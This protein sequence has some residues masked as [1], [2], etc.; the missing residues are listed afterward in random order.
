MTCC[1]RYSFLTV[2]E[3]GMFKV[4][5]LIRFGSW[6]RPSW[7]CRWLLS[8][9]PHHAEEPWF[10]FP[11]FIRGVNLIMGT[12]PSWPHQTWFFPK[13]FNIWILKRHIHF[14]HSTLVLMHNSFIP[15]NPKSLLFPASPLKSS[16]YHFNQL[17]RLTVWFILRQ[18]FSP[19]VNLWNQMCFQIPWSN[20]HTDTQV[21]KGEK[22]MK[23]VI[24]GLSRSQN[25]ARQISSDLKAWEAS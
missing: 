10:L 17:V 15:C 5:V 24:W 20:R 1:Y 6:C 19:A 13:G 23:R 18:N 25:L 12:S 16:K 7:F 21:W 4:M 9:C 11:L 8:C 22:K 2:L 3:V 14:I